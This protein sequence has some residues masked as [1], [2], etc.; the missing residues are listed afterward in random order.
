MPRR[1]R[2]SRQPGAW[3][4]G[5]PPKGNTWAVTHGASSARIVEQAAQMPIGEV[6]ATA[7]WLGDPLFAHA[8][9]RYGAAV[10][11]HDLLMGHIVSVV[12]EKGVATVPSRMWEQTNSTARLCDH[13]AEGLGLTPASRAQL[14]ALLTSAEA[15]QLRLD[16]LM[17]EGRK[18]VD[19]RAQEGSV[20]PLLSSVPVQHPADTERPG[21]G[22]TEGNPPTLDDA[23]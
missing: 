7:P 3:R 4:P 10:A 17:S 8:V 22:T 2:S 18:L 15:G 14:D 16:Q 21:E 11:R 9:R 20:R 13:L 6:L 1:S 23:T 12:N 19:A 5:P